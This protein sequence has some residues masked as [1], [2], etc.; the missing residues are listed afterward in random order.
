MH[1]TSLAHIASLLVML[2][3]WATV[4]DKVTNRETEAYPA[5]HTGCMTQAA[6]HTTRLPWVTLCTAP[7]LPKGMPSLCSSA[8]VMSTFLWRRKACS[9][10][11][12]SM[13]ST[14]MWSLLQGRMSRCSC[15]PMGQQ[16][17]LHQT[18]PTPLEHRRAG[19]FCKHAPHTV[20]LRTVQGSPA[21]S[22]APH[23]HTSL[24][25]SRVLQAPTPCWF[26]AHNK[27]TL[28]SRASSGNRLAARA[29]KRSR[30]LP[31]GT[32]YQ[33]YMP[34]KQE[35]GAALTTCCSSSYTILHGPASLMVGTS[36]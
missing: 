29:S 5:V 12:N 23:V 3:Y 32:Q 18:W 6:C 1:A 17:R 21:H 36:S 7:T 15:K 4:S 28:H 8:G 10:S 13:A 11:S 31:G 34:M 22:I 16:G 27:L 20:L 35:S 25:P 33:T 19:M 30:G 2:F 14:A 9:S 24:P 26:N